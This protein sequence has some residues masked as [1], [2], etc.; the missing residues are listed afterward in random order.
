MH[1]GKRVKCNYADG[2]IK[3]DNLQLIQKITGTIS[4]PHKSVR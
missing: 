3:E 2:K 1:T 4:I